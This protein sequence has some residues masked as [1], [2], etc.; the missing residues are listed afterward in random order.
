MCI[1]SHLIGRRF[2]YALALLL[3]LAPGLSLP[4]I[5]TGQHSSVGH[6]EFISPYMVAF[7]ITEIID[8][9]EAGPEIRTKGKEQIRIAVP[10]GIHEFEIR[11]AAY[12]AS[13]S[14]RLKVK[15]ETNAT[16]CVSVW[17]QILGSIVGKVD[18]NSNRTDLI[19]YR[20][21]ISVGSHYLPAD[22]EGSDPDPYVSGLEDEDWGTRI[23]SVQNLRRLKPTLQPRTVA[24]LARMARE[25]E[26]DLV[27]WEAKKLAKAYVG[28]SIE[29]PLFLETF[30]NCTAGWYEIT[31]NPGFSQRFSPKGYLF[32]VNDGSIRFFSVWLKG[33]SKKQE[34]IGFDA[35]FDCQW[36]EGGQNF[37]YGAIIGKDN[38]NYF[39]FRIAKNGYAQ[40]I[41]TV[42]GN[43]VSILVAENQLAVKPIVEQPVSRIV[44][45][46]RGSAYTM[47][48]NG[49]EVGSFKDD[50]QVPP[51]LLGPLVA[52]KQSVLFRRIVVTLPEG[53]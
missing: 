38:N 4:G 24:L 34:A 39:A 2:G 18:Y 21:S 46:K 51:R 27:R 26:V 29:D 6:V 17:K 35:A 23:V 7:K 20:L 5:E 41:R 13:W 22:E 32:S 44:V 49:V 45:S 28:K 25:D 12:N 30:E 10:P 50:L 3:I 19:Y 16:I 15:V 37:W 1:V 52:G 43:K 40:V 11:E 14:D 8:G 31:D 53:E 42:D 36:L 47:S 48:V 9:S 33:V